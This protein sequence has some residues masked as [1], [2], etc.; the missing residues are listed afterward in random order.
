MSTLPVSFYLLS[1]RRDATSI[2]SIT[3]SMEWHKKNWTNCTWEQ[4]IITGMELIP[5][6]LSYRF[7]FAF[8][9]MEN[10]SYLATISA[11]SSV[12]V[13]CCIVDFGCL[14]RFH[15]HYN[16]YFILFI[17]STNCLQFSITVLDVRTL[18]FCG[19][20]TNMI[21]IVLI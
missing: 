8:K 12:H 19:N 2:Y 17:I 14:P 15:S 3:C 6:C 10:V 9:R 20:I 5:G 4:W 11:I 1:S 13:S 16:G 18:L 7:H 21:A